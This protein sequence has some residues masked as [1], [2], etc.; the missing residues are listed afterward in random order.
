MPMGGE[1]GKRMRDLGEDEGLT[2][3]CCGPAGVCSH[4][5]VSPDELSW[6]LRE[7]LAGGLWG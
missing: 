4:S 7:G 5:A 2:L 6:W 3:V 1:N